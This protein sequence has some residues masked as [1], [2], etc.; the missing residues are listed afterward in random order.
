MRD[1]GRNLE[2]NQI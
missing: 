2:A 1:D